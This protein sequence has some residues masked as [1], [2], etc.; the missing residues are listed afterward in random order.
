MTSGVIAV[1]AATQVIGEGAGLIARAI[2]ALYCATGDL[3]EFLDRHIGDLKGNDNPVISRT[4]RVLEAVKAGFGIG[5]LSSTIVIAAGQFLLGNP[6]GAAATIVTSAT[7]SN[8]IAMTCAAVGA[9][10]YGWNALSD[11]ER[12]EL[13]ERL[14]QGLATG[15]ELV[16]SVLRF[17]VEKTNELLSPNNIEEIKRFIAEGAAAFGRTLGDVTH[18]IADVVGDT[19]GTA[20]KKAGS[21]LGKTADVAN[22]AYR[23]A[24]NGAD[25]VVTTV[26]A[27]LS[28][29]RGRPV[30]DES[31]VPINDPDNQI[32]VRVDEEKA[33]A[34]VVMELER[35]PGNDKRG[36]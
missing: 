34:I 31:F 1:A 27:K 13:L 2:A 21:A 35:Q 8:P 5:Y 4:G 24:S 32:V 9:V 23:L 12:N 36:R 20:R 11:R 28:S 17:L 29:P 19:L 14:S 6:L 7:L 22:E 30:V 3:N 10:F 26:R 33:I 16:K 25:S 15:V 18:R